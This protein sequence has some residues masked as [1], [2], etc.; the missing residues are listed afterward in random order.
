MVAEARL[1]GRRRLT[2]LQ[3]E[4][5]LVELG[6]R[7]ATLHAAGQ[8]AAGFLGARIL[9]LGLG[10]LREDLL[11]AALHLGVDRVG[12]LLRLH[13]DMRDL[14][15]FLGDELVLVVVEV[16]LRVLVRDLDVGR[17]LLEELLGHLLVLDVV[18]HAVFGVAAALELFLELLLVALEV[19][20][21]EVVDALVDVLVR[22][23]QTELLGLVVG[24]L[25]L[26]EELDRLAAQLVVLIG[27]LLREVAT[28]VLVLLLR[29]LDEFVE[30][31]LL[32]ADT[33][34]RA[35]GVVRN[36]TD[37]QDTVVTTAA[38]G[39]ECGER[40][41]EDRTSD[42]SS[43]LHGFRKSFVSFRSSGGNI[44]DG[45]TPSKDGYP[46]RPQRVHACITSRGYARPRGAVPA[47]WARPP[48]AS[49]RVPQAR[50]WSRCTPP[51]GRPP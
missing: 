40:H 23:L 50:R 22:D 30:R 45:P 44:P 12:F 42:R 21:L 29:A 11:V 24:Q 46:A 17:D 36:A 39:D 5:H 2:V 37:A 33:V 7:L 26:H 43:E 38:G 16:L 4:G 13:Q 34:D 8:H 41:G 49:S 35:E 47:P 19:L 9:R 28:V 18:A 20:L 27:A 31:R 32:Q 1:H 10:Q 15:R 3:R 6:H 48:R 25:L 14:T 51:T